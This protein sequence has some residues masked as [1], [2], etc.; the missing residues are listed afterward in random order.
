MAGYRL[1][2]DAG[3]LLDA[4]CT[5]ENG[6]L[7]LHARGDGRNTDYG[8]ALRCI[9]ERLVRLEMKPSEAL[10]DSRPAQVLPISQRSIYRAFDSWPDFER[11]FTKLS[12]GM[13]A[14]GRI[15]G[16]KGGNGTKRLRLLLPELDAV[17]ILQA[18]GLSEESPLLPVTTLEQVR[19]TH[20]LYAVQ[21]M[22]RGRE[23]QGFGPSTAYD[24]VLEDGTRLPPKQ[25]FGL[26]LE[27]A[28]AREVSGREFK[29]GEQSFVFR[30]LREF[31]YFVLPKS[32]ANPQSDRVWEEGNQRIRRHTIRERA[33]GLAFAKKED[34]IRK[35]GH[36]FCER[37][38]FNPEET[39][40]PEFAASIIEVHHH[41]VEVA[42]MSQ[43]HLTSLA[44]LQCLCANCH[45]YVHAIMRTGGDNG[46][47]EAREAST[48]AED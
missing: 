39:Y 22:L 46:D 17:A 5:V 26:A 48:Q 43:D 21:E 8:K 19:A 7:V 28:L 12:A 3:E 38:G 4:T 29:G 25:V 31:G 44:D 11:I 40:G 30:R 33:S 32:E 34:F 27:H 45:R 41:R 9:L 36:L 20:V 35:H 42:H 18:L 47:V 6:A 2:D 13:Q 37:C 15:E 24:L 23:P 14:V 10:V 16:S 1:T